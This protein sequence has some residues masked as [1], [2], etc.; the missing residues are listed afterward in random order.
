MLYVS[1]YIYRAV[2]SYG[3]QRA[4][5]MRFSGPFL[6]PVEKKEKKKEKLPVAH[7]RSQWGGKEKDLY[8]YFRVTA[9]G[10]L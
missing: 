3:E 5:W 10:V 6:C 9:A 4:R 7:S 8:F 1:I 2:I